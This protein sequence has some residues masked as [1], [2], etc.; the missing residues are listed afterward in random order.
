MLTLLRIFTLTALL[1]TSEALASS[2]ENLNCTNDE[3]VQHGTTNN[4]EL[5]TSSHRDSRLY[6]GKGNDLLYGGSG[7]DRL[8]GGKGSD[9]LRGGGGDDLI[10]GGEGDDILRGGGGDDTL[11]GNIGNNEIHGGDGDDYIFFYVN[12]PTAFGG[13]YTNHVAW[14]ENNKRKAQ[15]GNWKWGNNTVY[16]GDGNDHI[17]G[18][19]GHDK[20]HGGDGDD[21][22]HGD[23]GNDELHGGDGD[24]ILDGGEGN[25]LIVFRPWDTGDKYLPN[26]NYLNGRGLKPKYPEEE[27]HIILAGRGWPPVADI[28]ASEVK[29]DRCFMRNILYQ[30]PCFIYTLHQDLTIRTLMKLRGEKDFILP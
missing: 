3:R 1:V 10:S 28:L 8:I 6:G 25:N 29:E 9:E 18:D 11:N 12:S 16:G 22:L 26:F 7:R 23:L 30:T 14:N 2:P 20:I 21:I 24:D 13:D 17:S 15:N 5:C 4:D 19:W 27:D